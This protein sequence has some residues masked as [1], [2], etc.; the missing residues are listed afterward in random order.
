MLIY[1]IYYDDWELTHLSTD[2][3][4]EFN[5]YSSAIT[6]PNGTIFLTGGGVSN[7]VCQISFGGGRK[8]IPT[9]TPKEPMLQARKEHASVYLQNCVYVLGGYNGIKNGFLSSC[10]KYDLIGEKWIPICNMEVPKC[11][12]GATTMGNRYIFTI[13]GYDGSIRLNIVERYDVQT[14]KWT[15]LNVKMKQPLSN[16]AGF[17]SSENSIMVLGGG[18]NI[19]FSLEMSQLDLET[20]KWK[21][22]PSMVDG[23]DLRNKIVI[24]NEEVYAIGGNNFLVEKFSLRKNDWSVATT[25]QELVQDNLDSWS[26]ALYYGTNKSDE[27]RPVLNWNFIPKIASNKVNNY[28]MYHYQQV[29]DDGSEYSVDSIDGN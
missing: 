5:Y 12:F 19:G 21:E 11:A 27:V 8:N 10:E 26:C 9:I 3:T 25:Y 28:Q 18:H 6:L 15:L 1:Y 20:L 16:C 2:E 22:F 24:F 4:Y 14:D 17:A 23:K 13:G 29:D 7:L